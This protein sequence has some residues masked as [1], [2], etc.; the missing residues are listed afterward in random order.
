[1]LIVDYKTFVR[2][3]AGTVYSP[4]EPCIFIS[5]HFSIKT[6]TGEPLSFS[7]DA[8]TFLGEMP[9]NPCFLDDDHRAFGTGK[10]QT[11]LAVYDTA[12]CDYDDD[13]LFAVLERHEIKNMIDAL[14]WALDGCPGELEDFSNNRLTVCEAYKEF[15]TDFMKKENNNAED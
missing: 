13:Q 7:K 12:A 1:M 3:P 4:Y 5:D 10:F 11:V 2:M 15:I 6:D 14:Y 8:W 9:L